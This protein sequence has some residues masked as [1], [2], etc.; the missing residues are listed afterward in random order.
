M[1][2][3]GTKW[4]F[5]AI[6]RSAF[7]KVT[8]PPGDSDFRCDDEDYRS[9]TGPRVE[10]SVACVAGFEYNANHLQRIEGVQ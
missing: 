6:V 2:R 9:A 8:P 5:V 1:Y 3:V 10:C 7:P 4:E